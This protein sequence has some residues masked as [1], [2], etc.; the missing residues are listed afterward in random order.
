MSLE[1]ARRLW[2][3]HRTA[4]FPSRL[5]GKEVEGVDM[6]MLDADIAG[7]VDNWLRSGG[8]LDDGRRGILRSCLDDLGR[9]LPVLDEPEE[10]AYYQRLDVLAR[11]PLA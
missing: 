9:V 1:E 3:E 7:C 4:P 5:R 10:R 2:A 8:Q 11:L 6:A